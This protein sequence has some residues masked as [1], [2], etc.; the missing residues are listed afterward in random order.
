MKRKR[1]A[2]PPRQPPRAWIRS[3]SADR[4]RALERPGVRIVGGACA[5]GPG[6]GAV[7]GAGRVPVGPALG[8]GAGSASEARTGPR[9]GALDGSDARMGLRRGCWTRPGLSRGLLVEVQAPIGLRA[10]AGQPSAHDPAPWPRSAIPSAPR[11][12]A[13]CPRRRLRGLGGRRVRCPWRGWC[14]SGGRAVRCS[15]QGLRAPEPGAPSEGCAPHSPDRPPLPGRVDPGQPSPA[16]PGRRRHGSAG[17][18]APRG[19]GSAGTRLRQGA[20][21]SVLR[22]R[23]PTGPSARARCPR[24]TPSPGGAGRPKARRT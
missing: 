15:R 20:R 13:C 19:L 11:A 23:P 14:A 18:S 10:G 21:L 3:L 24:G 12:P 22:P 16:E 5:S 6:C 1:R 2:P 4:R 9:R 17:D 7:R 8:A